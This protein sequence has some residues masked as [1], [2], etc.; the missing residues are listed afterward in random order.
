[1]EVIV[2][3]STAYYKLLEETRT[4]LTKAMSTETFMEESE[5][6]KLCHITNKSHFSQFRS[7][8]QIPCYKVDRSY[9]YKRSEIETFITKFK[10]NNR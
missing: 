1:M 5:V 10:T 8:H 6:M 4:H 7:K 9:I 2:I 3:E